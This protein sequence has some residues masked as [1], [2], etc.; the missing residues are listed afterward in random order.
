MF[1]LPTIDPVAFSVGPVQVH[2]YGLM[3][4]FAFIIFY[5][6]GRSRARNP[7]YRIPIAKLDDLLFYGIIG[8]IVGGRMGYM[9]FYNFST[10]IAEPLSLFLIW[11]G[12]MSFHGGLIGVLVAVWIFARTREIEFLRIMDFIAPLVPIGLGLG[13]IGNFI[14]G[15]LWGRVTDVPWAV[16]FP[17]A[18]PDPRH[19]SQLYECLLEGVL[20]FIVLWLYSK[21]PRPL[22]RVAAYFALGYGALRFL[23]EFSREPDAHIGFIALGWMTMGQLLSLIMVAVGAGLMFYSSKYPLRGIR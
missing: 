16:V 8:V 21:K 11:Q 12:G 10:L 18:G 13:R 15:E 6:L 14:N 2:W 17:V 4:L 1:Y 3:Y 22:G 5:I 23:V 7:Q 20:L 19:P 9:L